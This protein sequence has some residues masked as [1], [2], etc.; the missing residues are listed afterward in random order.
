MANDSQNPGET[1]M[2]ASALIA[3]TLAGAP[4]QMVQCVDVPA[5]RTAASLEARGKAW[6]VKGTPLTIGKRRY[7]RFGPVRGMSPA[8]VVAF[9]RFGGATVFAAAGDQA[10]GTVYVL[11]DIR[12]C[13]FQGYRARP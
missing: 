7:A 10:R 12:D 5:G 2:F 4:T 3:V 13:T 6:F 11:A 8:E 9:G 1:K